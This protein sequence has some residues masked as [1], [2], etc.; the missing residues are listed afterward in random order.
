MIDDYFQQC[1]GLL[2]NA[3][4]GM[5]PEQV[6]AEELKIAAIRRDAVVFSAQ[7]EDAQGRAS[8]ILEH[9]KYNY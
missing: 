2:A 7:H 3:F 5:T 9:L 8:N 1:A 6:A 4:R